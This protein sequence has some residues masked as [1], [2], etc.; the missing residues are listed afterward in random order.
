MQQITLFRL[1]IF[2][3]YW[4]YVDDTL[5]SMAFS[6]PQKILMKFNLT[7]IHENN[8]SIWKRIFIYEKKKNR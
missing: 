8:K 2:E 6:N 3:C 7:K 5:N 1:F 4:F